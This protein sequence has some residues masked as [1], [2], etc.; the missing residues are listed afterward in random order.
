M[1][2]FGKAKMFGLFTL[3]FFIGWFSYF[4]N[5]HLTVTK[6]TIPLPDTVR[7]FEGLRIVQLSDLHGKLFGR[8]QELLLAKI[9]GLHPDMIV[10]TGDLVDAGHYRE[11]PGLMLLGTLARRCPVFMVG[12]NHESGSG[13]FHDLAKRLKFHGVR[14]LRDERLIL[15]RGDERLAL[16]GMDDLPDIH[17]RWYSSDSWIRLRLGKLISGLEAGEGKTR[18]YKILLVHRPEKFAIYG[19]S[20]VNLVLT[21]HA[22]GGQIRLPWLGGLYAPGQGY[23]PKLTSGLYGLPNSQTKMIVNRGLGN[24]GFPQRLGN[25]PEIGLIILK[26]F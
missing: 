5:N 7:G 22:H 13:R 17:G 19:E 2:R 1:K 14:V 8:N 3:F 25:C 11:T 9:A 16:I 15:A 6:I 18:T 10:F 12:G 24:S 21:G 20:G 4:E 26:C 23:F